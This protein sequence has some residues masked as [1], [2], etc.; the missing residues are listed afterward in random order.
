[1]P[2]DNVNL[3]TKTNSSR[4]SKGFDSSR[5]EK[6]QRQESGEWCIS[7]RKSTSDATI[8]ADDQLGRSAEIRNQ[9][10]N[11]LRLLDHADA[12]LEESI[13]DPQETE[14]IQKALSLPVS[15]NPGRRL[16]TRD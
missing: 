9:S 16:P 13:M 6:F 1:M 2:V 12:L 3:A 14:L 11:I 7:V 15:Q 10:A 8:G 4:E 5:V